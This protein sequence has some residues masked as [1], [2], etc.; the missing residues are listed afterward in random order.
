MVL[1]FHKKNEWLSGPLLAAQGMRDGSFTVGDFAL[2]VY[3]LGWVTDFIAV[4]GMFW[5][6]LKQSEVSLERMASL[7]QGAPAETLVR[8]GPV[9][10]RGP[11]PEV[12]YAPKTEAHRL[13]RLD[14][15]GLTCTY[16]DTGR[17]VTGINLHLERGSFTV[18]TGRVGSGKTTLVRGLFGLL[19]LDAGEIRWNGRAVKAPATF[20]VPPRTAYTAQVPVLFS[21]SLRDNILLGLPEEQVD[22]PGAIRTAVM[23]RDVAEWPDGLDTVIG[24]KGVRISGGQRQR[25]AAARML[26]RDP[27]LLVFD[28]LSSALDVETEKMLWSRVLGRSGATCLA[29]SHR[30]AV[31][32]RAD[33][34]VVLKDSRME[35]RGTLD[36]LL[37]TCEEMQRLWA[38]ELA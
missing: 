6:Q 20:F 22:L 14:V 32:R 9:Y 4:F 10:L 35:A 28:D 33:Q 21:E 12:A 27:E 7:L 18:I 19:P 8:H 24:V 31:L 30:H 11:L 34:V 37:E 3:Y 38:G 2:F 16:P 26:V 15:P 13:E 36:E 1:F 23:E 17:G 25:T 29:V 5:R